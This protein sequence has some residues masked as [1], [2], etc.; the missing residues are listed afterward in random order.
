[1]PVSVEAATT[2]ESSKINETREI[3]DR[4][5]LVS[6]IE[7]VEFEKLEISEKTIDPRLSPATSDSPVLPT[8]TEVTVPVR[9]R[10][11]V[12]LMTSRVGH[13]CLNHLG[14]PTPMPMPMPMP[15]PTSASV[16]VERFE[17]S[18]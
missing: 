8:L 13:V 14:P 17:T 12:R 9:F 6:E 2:K 15:M 5:N 18:T 11:F 7:F 1:L 4:N 16:I 10:S 3:G